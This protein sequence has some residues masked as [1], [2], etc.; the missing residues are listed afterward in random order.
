MALRPQGTVDGRQIDTI[1]FGGGTP[2]L[3]SGEEVELLLRKVRK[4]A[5]VLP[6]A[7][8]SLEAN[9]GTVTRKKLEKW[10]AAESTG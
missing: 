10:R 8:V 9:P 1:F 5:V 3:L 7:E 4:M 2:S 6:D